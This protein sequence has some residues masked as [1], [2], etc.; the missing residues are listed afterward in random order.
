MCQVVFVVGVNTASLPGRI[1]VRLKPHQRVG[2]Y[3]QDW[4][5]RWAAGV[6]QNPGAFAGCHLCFLSPS[7]VAV[8]IWGIKQ[9]PFLGKFGSICGNV[10]SAAHGWSGCLCC[11]LQ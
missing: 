1:R 4:F 8:L 10:V 2:V 9:T 7:G 6:G 5:P 3:E 11:D